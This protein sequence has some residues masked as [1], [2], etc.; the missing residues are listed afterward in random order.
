MLLVR[1]HSEL[2]RHHLDF[3]KLYSVTTEFLNWRFFIVK[4]IN[5]KNGY[6][7]N[8]ANAIYRGWT[9]LV[10]ENVYLY[11]KQVSSCLVDSYEDY[12]CFGGVSFFRRVEGFKIEQRAAIEFYVK[13]KITAT[14][15][16]EMVK[17]AYGEECL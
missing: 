16:F 14:E 11:D 7:S 2:T 6:Y 8:T 17:S 9:G 15:T 5:T 1:Q 10:R 4:K 12:S 13:L 3:C